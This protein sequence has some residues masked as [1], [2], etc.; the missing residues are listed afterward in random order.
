MAQHMSK[1]VEELLE[2][3][4]TLTDV[5]LEALR[6]GLIKL[7]KDR[8]QAHKAEAIAQIQAIAA[9]VGVPVLELVGM[10]KARKPIA[11]VPHKYQNPENA[12]EVWTGRGRAP[13]WAQ[14]LMDAGLLENGRIHYSM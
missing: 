12:K 14:A 5:E 6:D 10:T 1:L 4:G 2:R 8:Q 7:G 3:A 9:S 11:K 13:K